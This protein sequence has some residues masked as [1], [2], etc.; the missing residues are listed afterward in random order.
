MAINVKDKLVTVESLGIA[1]STE[2]GAR[3]EADQALSTRIDN[4]VAPD[5]DHSLTEVSDARVSG[6]TTYPTLKARLDADK[7]AIGTDIDE[8]KADLEAQDGIVNVTKLIPLQSGYYTL[9]TAVAAVY[10][11]PSLVTKGRIITFATSSSNWETWQCIILDNIITENAWK[12]VQNWVKV[13]KTSKESIVL[14]AYDSS[15]SAKQNADMY[16]NVENDGIALINTA[17]SLLP[18]GGRIYLRS[19][20]YKGAVGVAISVSNLLIE[21]ESTNAIISRTT[22]SDVVLTAGVENITLENLV[23]DTIAVPSGTNEP[24]YKNTIF[25]NVVRNNTGGVYDLVIAAYDSTPQ[26]KRGADLI[27]TNANVNA[28]IANAIAKLPNGGTIKFV[29][30]T[31][32]LTSVID[33]NDKTNITL[34]GDGYNTKIVRDSNPLRANASTANCI[35][36]GINFS[37][38]PTFGATNGKVLNCWYGDRYIELFPKTSGEIYIDPA[39]GIEGIN[40]AIGSFGAG[41]SG[42]KIVLGIG[43]YANVSGTGAVAFYRNASPSGYV[44]NVTI[45]GQGIKTIIARSASINDVV[46]NN[47]SI[48]GCILKNINVTHNVQRT[49]GNPVTMLRLVGCYIGGKYV[50]ESSEGSVNIVNVGAGRYFDT[51]SAA[52]NMFYTNSYP[53]SETERWE[54]HVWG[55][56]LETTPLSIAKN[57]IDLIGHNALIEMRGK[58]EVR[59]N[60]ADQSTAYYGPGLEISVR[61]IHFKKTGCYNYYQNYCVYVSSDNVKFY[62]C[63]FENAS[64]SPTPFDQRNYLESQEATAGARRHGI[65]IECKKWGA[66]CKTEFHDCIGI[67]SPYGFMNT[68]GWYI[69]FGSPKLFNCVGYGGGIGEFCHGIINHRSS[70]AELIGCIGYASKTAF[71]KSAGIR[72]QAAGSSHLTGCVGY[73]SGGTQYISEGVSA[74]RVTAICTELGV[75]SSTYVVGGVVQYSALTDAICAKI[76]NSDITL[77]S[78]NSNTEESYG[79]SFWANNGSAKLVNCEGFCGSGDNSHGLHCIGKATP[80]INGGYFGVKDMLTDIKLA[81]ND[82]VLMYTSLGGELNDYTKYTIT[83]LTVSITGTPTTENDVLY[84]QTDET[85]RKTICTFNLKNVSSIGIID[86]TP[87]TI[88]AGHGILAFIKRDGTNIQIPT[89]KYILHVQYNYADDNSSAVYI[90]GTANPLITNAIVRAA[91]GCDAVEIENTVNTVRMFDCALHGDIDSGITFATKTAVN[92]SSNYAI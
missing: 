30:G 92:S 82:G 84:V 35:L 41:T 48:S 43:T 8:I 38:K 72:F 53:I 20:T 26:A 29:A 36:Q 7:A 15:D 42:G 74:E 52:Y 58:G 25:G 64:S 90:G 45:E 75:D 49:V 40:N 69:V 80:V 71:R 46:A 14:A 10:G 4:I 79:I 70:Q 57:R 17:I 63:I 68:R 85:P 44:S 51:L 37:T 16:T 28:M 21:G 87:R 91:D 32:N 60:F 12:N 76:E 89:N 83:K 27:C 65:G 19:G 73:G 9:S 62:N 55:Y 59:A 22:G 3:Q 23:F 24:L 61:N 86:A 47:K 34:V 50:D 66:Q 77:T 2:K 88:A 31:Y 6:S 39:E 1:F 67:G 13:N 56:I 33:M 81:S 54:I 11:Y 78:L 18:N 5:G